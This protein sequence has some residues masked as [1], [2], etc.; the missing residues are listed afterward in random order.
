[1][2][3][4]SQYTIA[5]A[6]MANTVQD[7]WTPLQLAAMEGHADVV[8]VL[9]AAGADRSAVTKVGAERNVCS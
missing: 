1:M 7:Q 5:T 2:R 6:S 8:R 9:L 3:N 4:F